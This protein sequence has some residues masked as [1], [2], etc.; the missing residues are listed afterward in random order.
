MEQGIVVRMER[1]NKRFGHLHVLRDI[2]MQVRK[3][4]V[5]ILCGPSGSGK[6]TLLRTINGLEPIASGSI[7]VNDFS[8]HEKNCDLIRLRQQIGMVFQDFA[9]FPHLP[10]LDNI[11]LA[12]IKIRQITREKA[13]EKARELLA[14]V[15]LPEKVFAYPNELSGGQRQ[16][17]AIARALAMDPD[18]MLFDEPTSALDPE[19]I[20]G[21]L[22]IMTDLAREGMTMIVVTHEMGFAKAVGDTVF[23]MDEGRI[24]ESGTP[25]QV[26]EGPREKRTQEFISEILV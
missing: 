14:R 18:L 15:R 10:V 19:L 26:L 22:E 3:G 5:V 20:G 12:P 24:I 13:L 16:R 2:T 8:V 6:S 11:T 25:K 21:V 7:V 1:V 23:F 4:E 17:V 9:L